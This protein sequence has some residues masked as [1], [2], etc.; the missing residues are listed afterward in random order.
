VP[1]WFAHAGGWLD[2]SAGDRFARFTET[3]L[4]VVRDAGYVITLNEPNLA[5]CLPVLA[6]IAARGEQ[7]NGLPR[8]I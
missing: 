6:A 2:V 7:V 1:R 8:P 5:A 4:P 3:V